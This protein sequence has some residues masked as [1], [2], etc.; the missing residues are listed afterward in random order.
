MYW[1]LILTTDVGCQILPFEQTWG[2]GRGPKGDSKICT[3]ETEAEIQAGMVRFW[4][5]SR[6]GF[7]PTMIASYVWAFQLIISIQ[8]T[9]HSIS[10]ERDQN[11][12]KFCVSLDKDIANLGKEVKLVKQEAQNA[13]ILDP[14]AEPD[15][16]ITI[17]KNM[18]DKMDEF[19]RQAFQY[20][21]YQKGF[22]VS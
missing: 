8:L 7:M 12:D 15:Q 22:K 10:A 17:L 20:K 4:V 21:N 18:Q 3:D 14:K 1:G 19:Q 11:V 6:V 2:K 13:I 9:F 5:V 16:V